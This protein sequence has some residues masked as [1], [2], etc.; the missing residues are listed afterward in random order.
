MG[1]DTWFVIQTNPN[2]EL[3]AVGEI[4]SAGFRAYLPKR[5]TDFRH[6][7]TKQQGIKRRPALIGYVFMRFPSGQPNWYALRQC[8]GV[9][10]VLYC[11]GKPYELSRTAVAAIMRDQRRMT[12][13][14]PN[15]RL[16]R[17]AK[18]TG[19]KYLV[20]KEK[21][22]PKATIRDTATGVIARVVAV[23]K[24]GTIEAIADIMGKET[25]IEF[26]ETD[27]LEVQDAA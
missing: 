27:R 21:F 19:E 10:G 2:N 11:D 7:R 20:V 12:F 14:T 9:K 22:R 23:T 4:R 6:H 17:R 15:A 18:I 24:R 26:T 25:P 13:D 3:K 16:I 8:Q 1:Q 5:A